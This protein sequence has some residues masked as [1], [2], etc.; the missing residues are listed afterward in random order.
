ME[1]KGEIKMERKLASLKE[2]TAIENIKKADFIE[3]AVLKG[4]KTVV[5]K[6]SYKVGDIVIYLE[7]DSLI[8]IN[9]LTEHLGEYCKTVTRDGEEYYR[10]KTVKLRGEYSQGIILDPKIFLNDINKYQIGEDLT[11]I[12]G[13]KLY[14]PFSEISSTYSVGN[15]DSK[16]LFPYFIQKTDQE[17]VQNLDE[18][19][20]IS[21]E[22][23]EK[24]DG[25]SCTFFIKD[26]EVEICSRNFEKKLGVKNG[27]TR[28]YTKYVD[29]LTKWHHQTG[30]NIAIQGELIGVKIQRNPYKLANQQWH[31]FDVFNIDKQRYYT[32]KKCR[33]L[34]KILGLFHVPI[35]NTSY[36]FQGI[37]REIK[38]ADGKSSMCDGYREREGVVFKSNAYIE[39]NI[40]SFKIVSN[41]YLEKHNL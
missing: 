41:K 11:E 27:Y 15:V 32:P 6:D 2:I 21:F 8:P 34:C 19:P 12:L 5:S 25:T 31:V 29:V 35:I 39:G 1:V 36:K 33:D 28:I 13:I 37:E 4:W 23:T 16:G 17:R 14:D 9:N 24:L 18:I 22:L 26:G 20:N 30:K 38:L 40:F 3:L 10:I 7:I